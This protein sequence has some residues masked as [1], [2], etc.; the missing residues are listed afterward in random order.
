[1]RNAFGGVLGRQTR[2]LTGL[3]AAALIAVP[4][5]A[6][7]QETD[8]GETFFSLGHVTIQGAPLVS[9]DISWVDPVLNIYLLADRSNAS[10]DVV[11]IQ[12]NPPGNLKVFGGFAGNVAAAAC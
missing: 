2:L 10:V 5:L 7:A 9:F 12:V 11:P 8:G 3:A 1:M 4:S 6:I